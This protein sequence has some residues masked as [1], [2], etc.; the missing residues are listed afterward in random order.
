MI[1]E[2][3]PA[4]FSHSPKPLGLVDV[5]GVSV[6]HQGQLAGQDPLAIPLLSGDK[7][8]LRHLIERT[9]GRLY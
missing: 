4:Q 8:G 3:N 6:Q 2:I 5:R 7:R 1:L 9:L